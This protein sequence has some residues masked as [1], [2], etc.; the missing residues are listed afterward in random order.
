MDWWV[1]I[2][3]ADQA[4]E[5]RE[6]T[7]AFVAR[8]GYDRQGADTL[9]IERE[10]LREGAG[11]GGNQPGR[12]ALADFLQGHTAAYR[13]GAADRLCPEPGFSHRHQHAG[14]RATNRIWPEQ[15]RPGGVCRAVWPVLW[16]CPVADGHCAGQIR[17]APHHRLRPAAGGGG[18]FAI[19][20]GA[21]LPGADAGAVADW[22]GLLAGVFGLHPVR[23][24]ALSARALRLFLRPVPGGRRAGPAV[25]R[26]APGLGGANLELARGLCR[27]GCAVPAGLG[28]DLPPGTRAALPPRTATQPRRLGPGAAGL[29]PA[30]CPA[31][32]LG[33]RGAGHVV[34]RR[35]P[36]PAW[37]VAGAAIDGAV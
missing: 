34:L 13:S 29:F 10:G 5:L 12:I 8:G 33:H 32:H 6:D 36:E 16:H 26:H 15:C 18:G 14:T 25:Y 28:A 11:R 35:L 7:T 27:A 9:S 3:G 24:P 21:Q 20:P 23:G 30:V 2:V 17:P 31:A 37:A 22:R 19:G 4:L 1:R